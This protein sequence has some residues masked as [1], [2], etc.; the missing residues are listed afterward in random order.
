M[1]KVVGVYDRPHPL[2]Q[3]RVWVPLAVVLAAL[4]FWLV[5][6]VFW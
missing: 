3:R 1:A 2:R 6:F 5:F 4:A